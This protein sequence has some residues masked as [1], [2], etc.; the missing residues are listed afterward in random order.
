V[1]IDGQSLDVMAP[2][3]SGIHV[4]IVGESLGF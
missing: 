1:I 4:I 2:E 3:E